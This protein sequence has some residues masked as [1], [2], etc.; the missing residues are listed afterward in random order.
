QRGKVRPVDC[1]EGPMKRPPLSPRARNMRGL[2]LAAIATFA[3]LQLAFGQ[4]P[5]DRSDY[6]LPGEGG[7]PEGIAYHEPSGSFF[8]SGA[9]SGGV[10]RVDL[11]SGEASAF[12]EP[13]TRGSFTTIGLE[14]EG[15]Q[16]WVAGGG[17]GEVLVYDVT[18]GEQVA[19]YSTPEAEARFMNDVV[20]TSRG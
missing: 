20:V 3:T 6:E 18:T 10:Y 8:V 16:L 14:V 19:A 5:E 1:E 11:A 15:D 9:G 7:F 17:S 13:G 2:V 4:V 12:V